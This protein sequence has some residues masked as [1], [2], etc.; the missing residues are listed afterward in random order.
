MKRTQSL[1]VPNNSRFKTIS[2]IGL[3]KEFW[4]YK[5]PG[6]SYGKKLLTKTSL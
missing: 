1:K 4:K 6:S 3:S 2:I 5:I